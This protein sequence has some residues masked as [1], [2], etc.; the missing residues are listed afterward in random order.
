M[1]NKLKRII[2]VYFDKHDDYFEAKNAFIA[3]VNEILEDRD[4][5]DKGV[6]CKNLVNDKIVELNSMLETVL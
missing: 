1:N 6:I 5:G 4:D 3:D 2:N